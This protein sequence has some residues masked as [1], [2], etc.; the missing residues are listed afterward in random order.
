MA[1]VH[2]SSA[3]DKAGAEVWKVKTDQWIELEQR[4]ATE[5]NDWLAD[6]EVME[7]SRTVLQREQVALKSRLEA[8]ELAQSLFHQRLKS[9]EQE[10]ATQNEARA[11]LTRGLEK[12]EARIRMI[13][14]R[15]PEPL[16]ERLAPL[17]LRLGPGP[18]DQPVSVS[19]RVQTVISMLSAI[20]QFNGTVTLTHHLRTNEVGVEK[21]VEVLYWGLAMGY[22]V[23]RTGQQ[24]WLSLPS[25]DGWNWQE[26]HD[27][28]PRIRELIEIH[29]R[30]RSPGLVSL[31]AI[32]QEGVK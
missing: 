1:L 26:A 10:L 19:E 6:K 30:K 13:L 28:A 2:F 25:P 24:G 7:A 8:N 4:I 9:L 11:L 5:Q 3:A 12:E 14:D 17:Q 16:R 15:L 20:D 18:D 27:A 23:D 21:D 29:K 22:A 31:P 32:L